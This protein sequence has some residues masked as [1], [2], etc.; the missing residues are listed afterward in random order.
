MIAVMPENRPR[1]YCLTFFEAV[2]GLLVEWRQL[3][4]YKERITTAMLYQTTLKVAN[5]KDD[6]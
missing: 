2:G 5:M 4:S 1:N 3:F 6:V